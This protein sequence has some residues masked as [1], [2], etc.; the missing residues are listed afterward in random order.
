MAIDFKGIRD[1]IAFGT[2]NEFLATFNSGDGYSRPNR[3]EVIMKPPSGLLG[4][5]STK[6]LCSTYGT[7]THKRSVKL[8][9]LDVKQ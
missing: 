7:K 4:S 1:A 6:F 8:F 9:L 2:L 3:Y 5:E